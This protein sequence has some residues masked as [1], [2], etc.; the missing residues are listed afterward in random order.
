MNTMNET[1][2][3]RS[4]SGALWGFMLLAVVSAVVMAGLGSWQV[5]RLVWKKDLIAER[6]ASIAA[7][8]ITLEGGGV[9]HS[10]LPPT[11]RRVR[12]SGIYLNDKSLLV[13][14]RSFRALPHWR[15]VTPLQLA[16]GGIVL[17]DRG[18]VPDQRKQEA[19][20]HVFR[21]AG[22]VV[23]EGIVRQPAPSGFFAPDNVPARD[24]WFRVAPEKMGLRLALS[25][26][27]PFWVVAQG[28][29]RGDSFPIPDG[30]VTMP[31]NN[32]LQYVVTWYGLSLCA[33]VIAGFYWRRERQPTSGAG[34]RGRV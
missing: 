25:A 15:L 13:G 11:W 24:S 18:W 5:Q 34:I 29:R 7:P 8:P 2:Q 12:L 1:R 22:L 20:R 23:V 21:P 17:I 6:T 28:T 27:A 10:K 31:S 19:L 30:S 16:G 14:P 3:K 9:G 32:H 33:L 26:V 4:S